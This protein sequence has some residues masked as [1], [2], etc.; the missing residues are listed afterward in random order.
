M[1]E[2]SDDSEKDKK[3]A[4]IK[5]KTIV[6]E[7]FFITLPWSPQIYFS[8][9]GSENFHIY[10]WIAKDLAWSQG[11]YYPAMIFG[12]SALA[13]CLV[14]AYHAISSRCLEEVYMLIA[15]ILWLSA[16]FVWMAGEVFSGDDDYVVPTSAIIMESAI[17][18]ILFYHVILRPLGLI[19]PDAFMTARYESAGLKSRFSYFKNWRQYEHA[20]TL[21]WLGKDL[22][23]NQACQ[24]TWV[25]CLVPT[26]LIAADFIYVTWNTKKMTID[27]AH[28]VA[29]LMWVLGNM[30]WALGEVFN[31]PGYGDDFVA[32]PL[33]A[34]DDVA[35]HRTRWYS[36]WILLAAFI[37]IVC[38]YC[39]WLPLTCMGKIETADIE[40]NHVIVQ[41]QAAP[42]PPL[43]PP[44]QQQQ[45]QQAVVPPPQAP[46]FQEKQK[47]KN[48]VEAE[49]PIVNAM[50]DVEAAHSA[51]E[52][53]IPMAKPTASIL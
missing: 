26:I 34:T 22:S 12:T 41:Q 49:E 21:C 25:L 23:W 10:L 51:K 2:I 24:P 4:L 3:S 42:H 31:V 11:S 37:P 20:H 8:V 47:E 27:T 32:Y 18:W 1:L 17:A 7:N 50:H 29:Q 9:R 48:V 19:P 36:S 5:S 6:Q 28:Y 45:E 35:I 33:T 52:D 39:I 40:E 13:W 46:Q 43:P 53:Q 15:L 16:N 14:L 38:L 44:P 30:A